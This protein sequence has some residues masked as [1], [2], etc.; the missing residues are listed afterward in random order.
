MDDLLAPLIESR[1]IMF[2]VTPYE[3][4]ALQYSGLSEEFEEET[5]LFIDIWEG[6]ECYVEAEDVTTLKCIAARLL[7]KSSDECERSALGKAI[8]ACEESERLKSPIA[9]CL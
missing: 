3:I 6:E 5:G 2:E 1:Y 7:A 9:F 8:K 4:V